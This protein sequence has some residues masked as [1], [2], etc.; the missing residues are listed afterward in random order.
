MRLKTEQFA[1]G[2]SAEIVKRIEKA[3]NDFDAGLADDMNTA[4]ALAAIFD[5]VRD[6]NTAM[7]RGAFLQQDAPR[8][9]AAMEKFDDVLAVLADDDDEKL[10]K[11]GFGAS[12]PAHKLRAGGGA[13]RGAQCREKAPGFQTL[14]R[15][16]PK[17]DGFWYSG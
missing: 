16:P 15:N 10:R 6:V 13:D 1:A 14:R 9:I 12:K 7:D 11:L 2:S 4:A 3:E 5:L 17:A 8:A